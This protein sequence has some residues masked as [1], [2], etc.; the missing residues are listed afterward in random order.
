MNVKLSHNQRVR[1]VASLAVLFTAVGLLLFVQPAWEAFQGHHSQLQTLIGQ[2]PPERSRP[3]SLGQLIRR[4]TQ[5]RTDL[6]S[7]R[8]RFPISENVSQLLVELQRVL[9]GSDITRFYP[10]KFEQVELAALASADIRVLQQRVM[11]DAQGD[12][13]SLRNFIER[14]EN[15]KHPVQVRS[16]EI[17]S[18]KEAD[19]LSPDKLEM[20]FALSAFLLDRTAGAAEAEQRALETLLA[21]LAAEPVPT[22]TPP[23][24][25]SEPLAP[26]GLIYDPIE[27]TLSVPEA[28]LV[29]ELRPLAPRARPTAVP[30]PEP[31]KAPVAVAK[32]PSYSWRVMGIIYAR[33]AK[34]AVIDKGGEAHE[35]QVGDPV[36]AGWVV[37]RI[38][39]RRVILR[40]GDESRE[41]ELPDT[42]LPNSP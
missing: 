41:L 3:L 28:P 20:K 40:K 22:P 21:E 14:L 4:I 8:S 29:P 32:D 30:T 33:E 36:D 18:P 9:E 17:G 39:P 42:G 12:F 23:V 38:D 13:F 11:I 31:T 7:Q 25:L 1:L 10:T 5:T 27:R 19:P 26:R 2:L 15:F 16:F 6:E 24:E 35:Y 37:A 34:G